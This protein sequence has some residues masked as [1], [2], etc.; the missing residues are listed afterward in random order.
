MNEKKMTGA[1]NVRWDLSYFYDG[2]DDPRINRD[3]ADYEAMCRKFRDDYRGRLESRLADA[4]ADYIRIEEMNGKFGFFFLT[5]ST[6]TGNDRIKSR[7]SE[8]DEKVSRISSENLAFFELEIA[9][10]DE[11]Q[12][13]RQAGSSPLL[14]KHRP[15][16]RD[17]TRFRQHYLPEI[18]EEALEKRAPFGAG[19]WSQFVEEEESTLRFSWEGG[20]RNL[21]EMLTIISGDPDS[22]RRAEAM[23]LVNEGLGG[24]F[25]RLAAQA[26]YVTAGSKR[27]NDE[28]RGYPHSMASRNLSNKLPDAVVEA[29]HQAVRETAV[30]LA[31]RYYRLKAEHLGLKTL[32][33][34]DRN[35][36]IIFGDSPPIPYEEGKRVVLEATESFSPEMSRLVRRVFDGNFVD[37]PVGEN[38]SGGAYCAN[39]PIP[40]KTLPY[41]MLNYEGTPRDVSTMAHELGHAVHGLLAYEAQGP[42]M[43]HAPMAY[44]ETASVFSEMV[45]YRHMQ[46]KLAD[47]GDDR[48]RLSLA[49]GFADDIINTVVRQIS[50]SE[51]EKLLH[52]APRRLSVDENVA[53]WRKVTRDFYGQPGEIFTY[54][55]TDHLWSHISHFYRPYYVYSYAV[56]QLLT[57]SLFATKDRIPD[58]EA[59]YLD[60]LKAGGTK[61][62]VE[63][64]Q[65][66]GLD[67]TDQRF[68]ANGIRASLEETVRLAEELTEK[69]GPA[70]LINRR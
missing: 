6:D 41:V 14:Q 32:K 57:A 64:L 22:D 55:D 29:L 39:I 1:E 36:P 2:I 42:L 52:A 47:R 51:F 35:A 65:P 45:T 8:I 59:K 40:D 67:P 27:V 30:P 70:H 11:G 3:M 10:L 28:D 34:S 53:N 4:V 31:K 58:F 23:R 33:W 13:D 61:D 44:A 46:A 54:G 50:F 48:A 18:V 60:L 26:L 17:I 63:L 68:W 37:A 24:N 56:G 5:F 43:W 9:K 21:T 19:S 38:K 16:I 15:Y 25:A 20:E 66:F 62:A 49:M 7:M 12:I 69:V